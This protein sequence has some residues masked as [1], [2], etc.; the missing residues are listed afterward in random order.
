MKVNGENMEDE[1]KHR[2]TISSL[3]IES[4]LSMSRLLPKF[5]G[6]TASTH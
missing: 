6:R 1:L 4:N 5:S 2:S 3:A